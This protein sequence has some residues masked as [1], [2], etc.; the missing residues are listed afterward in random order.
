MKIETSRHIGLTAAFV[1]IPLK[2]QGCYF[3]MHSSRN[4]PHYKEGR[5]FKKKNYETWEK[6]QQDLFADVLAQN[7]NEAVNYSIF[8][9]S[10]FSSFEK[11][12]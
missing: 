8:W 11:F 2:V 12:K 1:M 3:H 5:I 10:L 7:P 6:E 4:C 9:V